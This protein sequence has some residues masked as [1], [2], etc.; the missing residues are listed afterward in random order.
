MRLTPAGLAKLRAAA[1]D[2][3]REAR[4]LVVD[5]LTPQQLAALGEASRVVL[6]GIDPEAAARF[7]GG[8]QSVTPAGA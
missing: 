2:H 7:E 6:R 1:P 5:A 8:P 4:R 3:V